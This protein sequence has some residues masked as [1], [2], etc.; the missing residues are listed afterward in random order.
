MKFLCVACDQPMV[1]HENL[2]IDQGAMTVVFA[3]PTCE[4]RMGMLAN[5]EETQMARSLGV[6]VAGGGESKCTFMEMIQ[7]AMASSRPGAIAPEGADTP[8]WTPEATARLERVPS[9]VRGMLKKSIEDLARE[10]GVTTVD[11]VLMDEASST[12]GM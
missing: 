8:H 1:V 7:E 6:E 12:L 9:F 3:C 4:W 2:G 11:D 5:P 10:K